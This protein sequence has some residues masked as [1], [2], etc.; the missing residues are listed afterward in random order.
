[1]SGPDCEGCGE[2]F[3]SCTCN[4][5]KPKKKRGYAKTYGSLHEVDDAELHMFL[6]ENETRDAAF[7]AMVCSEILRRQGVQELA[8]KK[9]IDNPKKSAY[10]STHHEYD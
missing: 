5:K 1:M 3:T 10:K 8:A 7:L 2:H 9:F 6:E 4:K